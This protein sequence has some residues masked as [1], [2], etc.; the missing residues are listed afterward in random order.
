MREEERFALRSTIEVLNAQAE[1][2]NAQLAFVRGR[3]NEY[4]GRVQLLAQVGTLAAPI[5]AIVW[6]VQLFAFGSVLSMLIEVE[7]KTRGLAARPPA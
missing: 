5:I 6:F 2:Q 3:A 4:V 1:L 7:E